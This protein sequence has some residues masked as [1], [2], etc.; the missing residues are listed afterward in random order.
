VEVR[1]EVIKLTPP[2]EL[3]KE[4]VADQ[5]TYTNNESL[6]IQKYNLEK[7]LE[8]C[9]ADKL[10]LRNWKDSATKSP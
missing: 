7:A 6:L 10:L 4:C 5:V 3:L 9:N 2:E 8:L 1:T